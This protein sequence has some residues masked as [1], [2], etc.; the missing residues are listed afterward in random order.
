MGGQIRQCSFDE[1]ID[2]MNARSRRRS[3]T[4]I[5][6]LIAG[7]GVL[8][9][10]S[11]NRHRQIADEI[12]RANRDAARTTSALQL[13]REQGGQLAQKLVEIARAGDEPSLSAKE[14]RQR[15]I[16]ARLESISL[17]QKVE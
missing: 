1:Q 2:A 9:R 14:Q 12:A 3:W 16:L 8:L 11:M 7:L 4:I 5:L 17:P 6:V 15:D 10:H 13:T